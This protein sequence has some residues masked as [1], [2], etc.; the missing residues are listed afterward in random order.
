MASADPNATSGRANSSASYKFP[1]SENLSN[2]TILRFVKYDRLRPDSQ[3]NENTV[4]SIFLP[5]PMGAPDRSAMRLSQAD[6]GSAGNLNIDAVRNGWQKFSDGDMSAQDIL[7][8]G[9]SYVKD[10][11]ERNRNMLS[12]GLKGAAVS[13]LAVGDIK[14]PLQSFAGAVTNPHT[15]MMFE[16]IGMKGFNLQW[17]LSPRSLDESNA[18]L[19]IRNLIKERMHPEEIFQGYGLN[20]PDL[21]YVEFVGEVK[22]WLPKYEKAF[23]SNFAITQ[24]SSLGYYKSGDPIEHELQIEFAELNPNTRKTVQEQN[25]R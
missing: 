16:G 15:T 5:V 18:L 2:G 22:K 4:A 11:I 23:I 25:K 10:Q 6:L 20:Y 21:V 19:Q 24:G 13:P 7:T 17:R 12:T 3:A 8:T 9:V 14:T 1:L